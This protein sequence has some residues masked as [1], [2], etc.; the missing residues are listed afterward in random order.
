MKNIKIFLSITIF[1]LF[2]FIIPK[3]AKAAEA[4]NYSYDVVNGEAVITK[5]TAFGYIQNG[6]V[7][8]PDTL[9]GY[10]VSSIDKSAF[11]NCSDVKQVTIPEG[12]RSIGDYAFS[13]CRYLT[14]VTIPKSVS[15]IG[16]FSFANCR[17]LSSVAMPDNGIVNIGQRAFESCYTLSTIKLP[18]SVAN[19]GFGAFRFSSLSEIVLPKGLKVIESN[20]FEGCSSMKTLT[21]P[22]SIEVIKAEAFAGCSNLETINA[23]PLTAPKTDLEAFPYVPSAVVLNIPEGAEGY[24]NM[25]WVQWL[26]QDS[27]SLDNVECT[28]GGNILC[29][30]ILNYLKL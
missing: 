23:N 28:S 22:S 8:I 27:L 29:N 9:G 1:M 18:T 5:Y 7:A 4:G 16:E 10:Q 17:F 20:V 24:N 14:S 21:L 19:I 2:V 6:I 15:S 11:A 25:P 12:I 13:N 26:N 30:I 3:G